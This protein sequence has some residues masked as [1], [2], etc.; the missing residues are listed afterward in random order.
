MVASANTRCSP[1][2]EYFNSNIAGGSEF[3]FWGLTANCTGPST[4]GC[5]RIRTPTGVTANVS[6]A[7]GTSA[8]I[9]DNKSTAGQASSIYFSDQIAP[10]A[11]FKLAQT[12]Q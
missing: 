1:V 3:F 11:A 6:E 2:T 10:R 8:I 12:G 4:P 7:G 5:V 9:I